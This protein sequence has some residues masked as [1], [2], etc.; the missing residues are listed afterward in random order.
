MQWCSFL[1]SNFSCRFQKTLQLAHIHLAKGK[2]TAF[3][4]CFSSLYDPSK[5]FYNTSQHLPI[6][7]IIQRQRLLYTLTHFW[8]CSRELL[9]ESILHKNTTMWGV[10]I[11]PQTIWLGS[12][13]GM[14]HNQNHWSYSIKFLLSTNLIVLQTTTMNSRFKV[15]HFVIRT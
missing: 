13:S 4:E 3:I 11:E 8:T 1:R 6:H 15:L 9:W 7:T 5:R 14:I 2:C 10:G 12:F